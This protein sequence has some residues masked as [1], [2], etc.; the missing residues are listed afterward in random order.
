MSKYIHLRYAISFAMQHIT[1]D[2]HAHGL[3][4]KP[5]TNENFT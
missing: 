1:K 4:H 3:R 2:K 5:Q